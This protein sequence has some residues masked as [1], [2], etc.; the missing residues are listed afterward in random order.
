MASIVCA[1]VPV[2]AK[3]SPPKAVSIRRYV[4]AICPAV[5][6]Y[7]AKAAQLKSAFNAEVANLTSLAAYRDTFA[8]L[9][10]DL[11]AAETDLVGTLT[12]AGA[13]RVKGGRPLAAAFLKLF[14]NQRDTVLAAQQKALTFSTDNATQLQSEITAVQ[15]SIKAT[16]NS[17]GYRV[18]KAKYPASDAA[19]GR[20]AHNEAACS[21]LPI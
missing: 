18:V 19:I 21:G 20:V 16:D 8:K 15:D 9:L 5:K 13:P 3:A 7:S 11:A 4:R 17:A 10:G 14:S 6:T 2:S 1:A 12:S